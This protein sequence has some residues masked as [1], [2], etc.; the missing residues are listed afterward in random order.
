MF[1]PGGSELNSTAR[2]SLDKIATKL[3]SNEKIRMQLMAYAGEQKMTASKARRLSLSR[4]L[5]VRTYL[6]S[7]GIRGTRIDVRALGNKLSS[8]L[9]NRVDLR[10]VGQ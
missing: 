2:K 1:A 4:A 10:V 9:P 3:N 8:G 6:I 5:A 7:K